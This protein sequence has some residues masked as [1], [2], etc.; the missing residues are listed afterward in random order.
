MGNSAKWTLTEFLKPSAILMVQAMLCRKA[1]LRNKYCYSWLGS[2]NQLIFFIIS[3]YG[4][5]NIM[6]N[7]T[8][9]AT[10]MMC[11]KNRADF[12]VI[13]SKKSLDCAGVPVSANPNHF[14]ERH[15]FWLKIMNHLMPHPS[16]QK[17]HDFNQDKG[18][19][20]QL[21][22]MLEMIKSLLLI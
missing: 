12:P 13:E 1:K 7:V 8:V 10:Q 22:A 15:D 17:N 4:S 2:L 14:Y 18:T 3:R 5:I 19:G 21:D 11:S 16:L 6:R 20:Q 9:A